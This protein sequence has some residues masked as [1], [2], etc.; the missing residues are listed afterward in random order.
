MTSHPLLRLVTID[1][2]EPFIVAFLDDCQLADLSQRTL[3]NYRGVLMRYHWWCKQQQILLNPAEHTGETIRRFMRYIQTTEERWDRPT[4]APSVRPAQSST[5]HVYYR[6][7]RRFYNWLVEVE[8]EITSSPLADVP[9]PKL[10]QEQPDPFDEYEL[11]AIVEVLRAAPASMLSVR[12]RAIVA[13]LLDVGV[14]ASELGAVGIDHYNM[15]TGDLRVVGGKG[16]KS[17][18]LRLGVR[19]RQQVRRYLIRYRSH[20]GDAGPLFLNERGDR[21]TSSGLRQMTED[22][23]RLARVQPCNPHRFRHTCAVNAIRAGMGTFQLQAILGHS[24]LEMVKRYVKLAESDIARAS[25]DH[26]PLDHLKLG[27]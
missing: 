10:P 19:A 7:L 18:T 14:R 16:N 26:S 20:Y 24:S 13:V 1:E 21:L 9:V 17:R 23:G 15:V 8:Q 12:N 5:R 6:V 25:Q 22:L 27:L 2:L 11:K 3:H 4:H